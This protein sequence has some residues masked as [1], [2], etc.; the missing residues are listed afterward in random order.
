VLAE[1]LLYDI[2]SHPIM[3]SFQIYLEEPG[4]RF[5]SGDKVEGRAVF[6]SRFD[7]TVSSVHVWFKGIAEPTTDPDYLSDNHHVLFRHHRE[8]YAGSSVLAANTYEWHF[9]FVF[10]SITESVSPNPQWSVNELYE[11]EPGHPLP[12]TMSEFNW[13]GPSCCVKYQLDAQV[14]WRKGRYVLSSPLEVEYYPRLD[15]ATH[16]SKRGCHIKPLKRFRTLSHYVGSAFHLDP[17]PSE[18]IQA[19][20]DIPTV[21]TPGGSVPLALT[22]EYLPDLSVV[23]LARIEVFTKTRT[24]VR[25][26][27]S[28]KRPLLRDDLLDRTSN[29]TLIDLFN[30][31]L[32]RYQLVDLEK[33]SESANVVSLSP[34]FQTYNIHR[35][36]TLAIQASFWCLDV[37]CEL[38]LE[39]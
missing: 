17:P 25:T 14:H 18:D 9:E 28:E 1:K 35:S 39:G 20:L 4:E 16:F 12:P 38:Q 34:G 11:H 22:L 27:K 23:K 26:L 13:S 30:L 7:Q 31:E 37:P 32:P 19:I 5:A 10:P 29:D 21:L 24:A 3:A 2:L 8:V 6:S 15:A 36:Y 33:V